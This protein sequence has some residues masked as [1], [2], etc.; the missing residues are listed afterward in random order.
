MLRVLL[1]TTR[2]YIVTIHGSENMTDEAWKIH[3]ILTSRDHIL[4]PERVEVVAVEPR[5][6]VTS[7]GFLTREGGVITYY[8][9]DGQVIGEQAITGGRVM[10]RNTL[11]WAPE[12]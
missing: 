9:G 4:P 7:A 5:Q 10:C 1:M 11:P 2:Q 8:D 6:H 12:E 3:T